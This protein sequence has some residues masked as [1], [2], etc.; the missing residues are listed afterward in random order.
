LKKDKLL[1][2]SGK[3]ILI[4]GGAGMIGSTI[5]H[6]ALSAG[7]GVT[8]VDAL[9]PL[10]GGNLFNLKDIEDKIR[11]VKGDI[12]DYTLM[13]KLVREADLIYNLAAQV[14]YIDSA[15]DPLLD[16]DINCQ[17]HLNVLEAVRKNSPG[18]KIIFSSS[19]FVYGTTEYSPVDERHPTNCLSI[20]GIHKLAA[21]KY[22]TFYHKYHGLRTIIFRIANPYG[23]RQ[24]MKHSK[25][26]I[27]NWFIR[28]ALSG[29]PLTIFGEGDQIRDYIFV[30]DLARGML[31]AADPSLY[32]DIFNI[33]SGVGTR[34]RNM[35][36]LVA[37]E[38]GGAEVKVTPFPKNYAF[39]ETGDYISDISKIRKRLGWQPEISI[40]EGIR[41]TVEYY[42]R[43]KDNY[44]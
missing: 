11:F 13:E 10:Y 16:L 1:K 26:G 12:R 8:V 39:T 14:S 18:A 31:S 25:Y 38:T 32:H 4:T 33:G 21:E 29:K 3:K 17:G 6:L 24:Q 43:F 9:L 19:R 20:Y 5:A 35:V 15:E 40:D 41:K 2:L 37:K 30:D 27:V 36:E 34:F 28:L 23:P 44:W 22:Y 42:T 7:A